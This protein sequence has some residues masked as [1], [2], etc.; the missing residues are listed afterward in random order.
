MNITRMII[1]AS[2]NSIKCPYA[3][4]PSYITIHNTAN[5]ASAKN[6][7]SYMGNNN[8]QVSFHIAFDDLGGVQGIEFNRNAWHAGDGGNGN[9]NR[10][11]IGV[12]ICYSKSGGDRFRKAEINS[13]IWVA[14]ELKKR[15]WGIDRVKRHK[16]WS[17]KNCPHRT[18]ADGWERY[19]N[20][21][22]TYMGSAPAPTPTPTPAPGGSYYP[23]P[24]KNT[25]SITDA[26]KSIGV[27]NSMANRKKIASANGIA[28]YTGTASQNTKM[29]SLLNSGK[30]KKVGASTPSAPT[31]NAYY[32]KPKI[33][34]SSIADA[35]KSVGV[36][37]SMANR[38]AIASKNG[39]AGYTGTASQN[40]KMLD[41]MKAGKLKK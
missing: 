19:L 38:K 2:K 39:I 20:L 17:G 24:S 26:L 40:T 30:L 4:T 41:L 6:E 27:D 32:P 15:G 9:G 10:K 12:E 36:N 29:L 33:N 25:S 21:V 34:T 7:V 16:D 13:A 1:P 8:N 18:I 35:L 28:G 37:N 11:S 31:S 14:I 22:K 3:M 5:D 23:K